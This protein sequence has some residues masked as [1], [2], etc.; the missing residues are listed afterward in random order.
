M[1]AIARLCD[2]AYWLD[3]GRVVADGPS[4]DDRRAVPAIGLR[5]RERVARTPGSA[6]R[7]APTSP[8]GSRRCVSSILPER[9]SGLSTSASRRHRVP[10]HRGAARGD[11][12][13]D[14]AGDH[15]RRGCLQR[16]R[17]RRPLGGS[18]ASRGPYVSHRRG[19]PATSSTR[20]FS[21]S[22]PG[23][24]RSRRRSCIRMSTSPAILSF[25]V[26]T[27]A[28]GGSSKGL[29]TGQLRGV[30]PTTARVDVRARRRAAPQYHPGDRQ[31][32]A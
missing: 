14:Q 26:T 20:D 31:S 7:I 1:Q 12:P 30:V 19:S 21:A 13:E 27:G 9:R 16:L 15:A 17:R 25:H 5:H 8:C 24:S 10:L 22:T 29:F 18:D 6:S 23:S 4:E 32:T 3:S 28:H 2:R 11:L